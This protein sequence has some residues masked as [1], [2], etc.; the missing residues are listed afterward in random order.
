MLFYNLKIQ[1]KL[2]L[3]VQLIYLAEIGRFTNFLISQLKKPFVFLNS[4]NNLRQFVAK[5]SITYFFKYVFALDIFVPIFLILI[6]LDKKLNIL[7][8]CGWYPSRVL[9][10]N[11]DFIQRHAKAVS[12][13]H[14]VVVLHIIS[15]KNCSKHIEIESSKIN[16][17][18]THIGYVKETNNS[19]LK[20]I[21]FWKVYKMLLQKIDRFDVVHL[22]ELFPF[23]IFALHLKWFKK[24]PFIISEH[25]TGYH[26]SQ[27]NKI[28][29][30]E[31]FFSKKIVKMATYICPVSNHLKK[32]MLTFGLKGNYVPVPNVVD[33]KLFFPKENNVN[34]FTIV[35]VS[36]MNDAHKNISGM[37]KVAKLLEN[38]GI[39]FTWNFIGGKEN[40]FSELL[41]KLQFKTATINFIDHI[42]QKDLSA[43]LQNAHVFV[44]FSNY[45]NLP[46]VILEAFSCGLPVISTHVGGI[47]EY[48]PK[49]FGVLIEK[50][51]KN[52]LLESLKKAHNKKINKEEMH[53]YAVKNFSEKEIANRFS[54]LY[55]KM[56]Q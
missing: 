9:P 50:G 27:S 7:F 56:L 14:T 4:S 32:A 37:L 28:S 10:T 34:R 35:H 40:T 5:I 33:T 47:S 1:T 44:L 6:F 13:L 11:G 43:Y 38:E 53:K 15:D 3:Y 30:Q 17:I 36:S 51:N 23:G 24:K 8:L 55:Y 19:I 2:I 31:K 22:N 54:V 52:Q 49:D 26:Q 41:K 12:L 25:W 29:F 16:G 18:I 42:S 46:C 45:E 48:F 21:R 39:N 20:C